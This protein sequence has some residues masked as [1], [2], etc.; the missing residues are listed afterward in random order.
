M[1]LFSLSLVKELSRYLAR[2]PARP[3][4]LLALLALR[5][6]ASTVYC[7]PLFPRPLPGWT[8]GLPD[9][10]AF[11]PSRL[12]CV[13]S[14]SSLARPAPTPLQC[15]ARE[16]TG[17]RGAGLRWELSMGSRAHYDEV[18]FHTRYAAAAAATKHDVAAFLDVAHIRRSTQVRKQTLPSVYGLD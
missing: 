2:P 4:A 17:L 3:P 16:Q 15:C 1:P 14:L 8:T 10:H 5:Q 12:C 6:P 18:K 7:M 13:S 9:L 11:F